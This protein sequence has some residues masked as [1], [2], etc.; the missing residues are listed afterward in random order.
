MLSKRFTLCRRH[1]LRLFMIVFLTYLGYLSIETIRLINENQ[2]TSSDRQVVKPRNM[3]AQ[4]DMVQKQPEYVEVEKQVIEQ[5]A[6]ELKEAA[7]KVAVMAVPKPKSWLIY[8]NMANYSQIMQNGADGQKL[9][10]DEKLLDA[11]NKKKFDE[12]WKNNA[13]NEYVS[14]KIPLNRTLPDARLPRYLD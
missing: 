7:P 3:P 4:E 11:E 13:F 8:D 12:G 6:I 1:A 9:T 5:P 2:E 14:I 10:I